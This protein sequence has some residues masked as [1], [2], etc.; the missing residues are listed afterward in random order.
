MPP[1]VARAL[2]AGTPPEA[3]A[4]SFESATIA[5]VALEDYAMKVHGFVAA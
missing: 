1:L 2:L 4:R 3:L 5:F